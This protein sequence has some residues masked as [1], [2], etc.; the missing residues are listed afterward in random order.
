M[1]PPTGNLDFGG[2]DP[3]T[4]LPP[5]GATVPPQHVGVWAKITG[6]DGGANYSVRQITSNSDNSGNVEMDDGINSGTGVGNYT[7]REVNGRTGIATDTI[8][9]LTPSE[10]APSGYGAA[11]G[12][13]FSHQAAAA[14][15]SIAFKEADGTP[16][17]TSITVAAFLQSQGFVLTQPGGAGTVQVS[18]QDATATLT[19]VVNAT[20]QTFAGLKT[21]N[22]GLKSRNILYMRDS[23]SAVEFRTADAATDSVAFGANSSA[24]APSAQVIAS[25]DSGGYNAILTADYNS[26]TASKGSFVFSVT[27]P[28]GT[29]WPVIKLNAAGFGTL[30]GGTTTTATGQRFQSGLYISGF[31]VSASIP[32]TATSAGS[33][34]QMGADANWLYVCTGANVWKRVAIATF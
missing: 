30:T 9:F 26:T 13:R 10:G 33:Q 31:P 32:A 20:T 18:I 1:R 15:A 25:D 23:G 4:D 27:T 11:E 16:N 34:G 5:G 19:G 6:S 14:A 24:G 17:Y 12:W 29:D 2:F 3:P 28:A 8:V 7:A 22:D 21:F